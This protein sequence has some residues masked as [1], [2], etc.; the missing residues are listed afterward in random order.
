MLRED[1]ERRG[2]RRLVIDS[3][4]QLERSI[5]DRDRRSDFFAALVTYLRGRQ[6]TTFLPYEIA[7]YG[8]EL[9]LADTSLAVLAENLL[10]LR[11]VETEGRLRRLFSIMHMRF[12]DHD[13]R[14]HEY[15]I[16]A[17]QGMVMQ[18]EATT[19]PSRVLQVQAG[20]AVFGDRADRPGT[21][22]GPT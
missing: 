4:A 14:L 16:E 6:V 20:G 17:G 22:G 2:V 21:V 3:A 5:V 10:L 1:I 7:R 9:D 15:T 12:S 19:C 11:A 13:H 8:S 18:G